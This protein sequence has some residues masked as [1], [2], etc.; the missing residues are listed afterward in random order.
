MPA[1]VFTSWAATAFF[2][3]PTNAWKSMSLFSSRRSALARLFTAGFFSSFFD[4]NMPQPLSASAA[5]RKTNAIFFMSPSSFAGLR[6]RLKSLPSSPRMDDEDEVDRADQVDK[7]TGRIRHPQ[8][9]AP[10][11]ADDVLHR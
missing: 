4:L 2:N 11:S 6:A 5:M 3:R 10:Q 8:R 9:S 7:G 1:I